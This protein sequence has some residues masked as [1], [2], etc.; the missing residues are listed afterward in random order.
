MKYLYLTLLLSLIGLTNT[1]AQVK[2]ETPSFF[3]DSGIVVWH[4]HSKIVNDDYTIYVNVPDGYDTT[5]TNYPVLY[6]NDGDWSLSI[7]KD[8][9]DMLQQDYE[10]NNP[11]IVAIGYGSGANKRT[12]D[13]DPATG[14]PNFLGFIQTE[15]MPF[16][17]SK[18]RTSGN[19]GLYGYSYGG[20][21][22]T[23]VLFNHP[24][25][26][27]T[28]FIGAPG[29]SG[30]ELIPSAQK[31]FAT[32]KELN[33]R[34]FVGVGSYEPETVD[35]VNKFYAYMLAHGV[36]DVNIGKQII[37]NGSHATALAEVLKYAMK[38]GY[39]K[40]HKEIA[41]SAKQLQK[42][43]GNYT[44]A[45]YPKLKFKL[46]IKD[47]KLYFQQDNNTPLRYVPFARDK[48]FMYEVE[49]GETTYIEEGNKKFLQFTVPGQKSQR[50][51]K[52]R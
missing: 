41:L 36:K 13:L 3:V 7:A 40:T 11:I 16:I 5:K 23:S 22:T 1:R 46:F 24:G 17:E 39:C 31:Y 34:I 35:N 28:V 51:D 25:L 6:L 8:A 27:N 15:L 33:S 20:M 48:F 37:P 9:F 18:Y 42:Y 45:P 43:I 49:R 47:N 44:Y 12:R 4:Y 52:V 32:H 10:T 21:F 50:L 29:N 38:F 14:G 30:R 19:N 2:S 26:F